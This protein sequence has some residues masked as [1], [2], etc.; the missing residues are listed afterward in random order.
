MAPEMDVLTVTAAAL[1]SIA[2]T[3]ANKTLKPADTQQY[4]ATG[5][6]TDGSTQDLTGSVTWASSDTTVATITTTGGLA[7]AVANGTTTISATD[8]VTTISGST[9]LT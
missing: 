5:T 8:P 7:T 9:T 2:V 6:F 1:K 4:T 3:P